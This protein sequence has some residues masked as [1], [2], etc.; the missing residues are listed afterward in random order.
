MVDCKALARDVSNGRAEEIYE[1][2]GG[3]L[4]LM[5]E[6]GYISRDELD[7]ESVFS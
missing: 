6:E 5:R 4:G 3:L 2:L 1:I 7:E